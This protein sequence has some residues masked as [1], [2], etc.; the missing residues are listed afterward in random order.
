MNA[1]GL[2]SCYF[3]TDDNGLVT[4]NTG[5][6]KTK[7]WWVVVSDREGNLFDPLDFKNDGGVVTF[8]MGKKFLG[9]IAI[10]EVDDIRK[11]VMIPKPKK[12]TKTE[13]LAYIF[14][15][16]EF[17]EKAEEG[18]RDERQVYPTN[19]TLLASLQGARETRRELLRILTYAVTKHNSLGDLKNDMEFVA[20]V[21]Q[22]PHDCDCGS[23][24]CGCGVSPEEQ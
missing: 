12:P 6:K 14:N 22:P 4:I 23:T 19:P 15:R 24:G 1:E 18:L 11:P 21:K 16:M 3:E 17:Y 5:L 9:T 2:F 10:E 13:I 7:D 8:S 20:A